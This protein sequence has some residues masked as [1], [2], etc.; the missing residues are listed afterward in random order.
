MGVFP[1]CWL[2]SCGLWSGCCKGW[3]SRTS[4]GGLFTETLLKA[5][6]RVLESSWMEQ[7]AKNDQEC[8]T[9]EGM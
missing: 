5:V 3:K 1:T 4:L 6:R 8:G 7:V 2:N 9:P